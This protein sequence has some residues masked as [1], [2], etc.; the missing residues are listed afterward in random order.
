[1]PSA[2][3]CAEES[4]L[5][6]VSAVPTPSRGQ[7]QA[8]NRL[9]Y[10]GFRTLQWVMERLPRRLAYALAIVV[11]RFAFLFAVNPRRALEA[12]LRVALPEASRRAVLRIVWRNFRYHSKGYCDLMR[13]P[14]ARVEELKPLMRI[15]GVE[16]L[17]EAQAPGRGVLVVSAH[18][19]SWEVAAAIWS[20]GFSPI[21]LFAEELEPPELYEWYRLTRARLG[22]SVL[23]L[24]RAGLRKV[25]QALAAEETVLTAVDRDIVGT[26][27][28]VPFFGR[29]AR[30]PDGPAQISLR[31][32]VPLLPVRCTRQPD[33]TYLT[34]VY[35]PIFPE[36]TGDREAD[37]RRVI[38]EL[39]RHLERMI[40][41]YPD[42]WHMPH[43]I[44]DAAR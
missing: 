13:M 2:R 5:D 41:E 26:G 15:D 38:G 30:I 10:R 6:T 27:V 39:V 22:I 43:R 21:N 44:W 40:R 25:L 33:D 17:A 18:M 34:V 23:P 28:E 31:Y 3:S 7:R 20:S 8:R 16:H 29:P 24:T 35:P 1:M 12:N 37:L 42:Q 19:G 11:A 36:P 14:R 32:G 4:P 9:Q